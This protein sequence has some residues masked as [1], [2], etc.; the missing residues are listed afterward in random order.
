MFVTG[1]LQGDFAAFIQG[2]ASRQSWVRI[3]TQGGNSLPR[4]GVSEFPPW[5]LLQTQLARLEQYPGQGDMA[6]V[7]WLDL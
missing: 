6:F 1:W 7:C 5:V 2:T 3:S 4:I